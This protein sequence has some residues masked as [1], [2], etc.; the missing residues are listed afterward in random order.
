MKQPFLLLAV[1][2][3]LFIGKVFAQQAN[4]GK[5]PPGPTLQP[6]SDDELRRAQA[7]LS[8]RVRATLSITNSL[9]QTALLSISDLVSLEFGID[10]YFDGMCGFGARLS[11]VYV[12]SNSAVRVRFLWDG[13]PRVTQFTF[14]G[15][16][17]VAANG[18]RSKMVTV[19]EEKFGSGAVKVQVQPDSPA[20]GS[21][22]LRPRPNRAPGAAGSHR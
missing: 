5:H 12:G 6:T 17:L 3:T 21:Q 1:A 16:N 8:Q 13:R 4:A 19:L 2:V 14:Y 7:L 9:S 11:R 10:R 15:T 18:W 22:P 20:N